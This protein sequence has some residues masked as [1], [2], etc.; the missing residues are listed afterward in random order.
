MPLG[1]WFSFHW[2]PGQMAAVGVT[3]PTASLSMKSFNRMSSVNVSV[4]SSNVTARVTKTMSLQDTTQPSG[5]LSMKSLNSM[6]LTNK[7]G[8]LTA[9]DVT[10]AV[11]TAQIAPGLTLKDALLD[12][13]KNAKLAAALS[14]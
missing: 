11:L 4:P 14:A 12:A 7:I 8:E 10:G 6:S 5:S 3:S 9:D 13:R 1:S 2:Y